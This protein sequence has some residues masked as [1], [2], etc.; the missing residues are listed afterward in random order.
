[1]AL[2]RISVSETARDIGIIVDSQLTMSVQVPT[3]CHS[4]YYQLRQLRPLIRSL[5]SDAV[6]TLVQAFILC[7]L[8]DC[9]S[10]FC[11]ITDGLMSRLQSVQNATARLMSGARCHDRIMPVLQELH[12]LPFLRWVEF[13]MA[14][15]LVYLSLSSMA[16]LTWLLTVSWSLT[17]VVTHRK[18]DLWQLCRQLFSINQSGIFKVIQTTARSTRGRLGEVQS[19]E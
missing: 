15:T 10:L 7:H 11:S 3:V 18:M 9:N 12:W 17:K 6:K 5:S 8:D 14:C 16:P 2:A 1:V 19:R 4:G 13:K